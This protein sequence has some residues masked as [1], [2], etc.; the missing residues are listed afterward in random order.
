MP[1][2]CD[3]IAKTQIQIKSKKREE[4]N[5]RKNVAVR[6]ANKSLMKN[7]PSFTRARRVVWNKSYGKIYINHETANSLLIPMKN[8]FRY[9][10]KQ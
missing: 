4:K 5:E 7:I 6:S 8:A 9:E 1:H 10:T 2:L 3:K